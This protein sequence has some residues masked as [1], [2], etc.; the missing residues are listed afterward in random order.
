MIAEPILCTCLAAELELYCAF[1]ATDLWR[2]FHRN[3]FVDIVLSTCLK[4]NITNAVDR[5]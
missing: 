5:P 3:C 2:L 4:S 1:P